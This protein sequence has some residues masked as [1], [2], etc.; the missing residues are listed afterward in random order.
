MALQET[1][2]ASHMDGLDLA[3]G[4]GVIAANGCERQMVR[5]P[6]ASGLSGFGS[7]HQRSNTNLHSRQALHLG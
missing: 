4:A 5:I 7:D 6:H 3:A 2:T 1:Y